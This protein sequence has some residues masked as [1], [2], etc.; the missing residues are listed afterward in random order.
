MVGEQIAELIN[1]EQSQTIK[2]EI[3]KIQSWQQ[4][5]LNDWSICGMNHY[6]VAGEKFLFVSMVKDGICITEEGK[7]DEYLWNRLWYKASELVKD[8]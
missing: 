8:K 7:D 3:M 5:P 6:H 2:G 1:T 4:T